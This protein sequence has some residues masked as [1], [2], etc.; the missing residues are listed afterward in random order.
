[1]SGPGSRRCMLSR[2]DLRRVDGGARS[3]AAAAA[4]GSGLG[5]LAPRV[6]V[7]RRRLFR[8]G[9]LCSAPNGVEGV[10]RMRGLEVEGVKKGVVVSSLGV[11]AVP[12]RSECDRTGVLGRDVM[13]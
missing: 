4:S 12:G 11:W 13:V 2:A 10:R 6:V 1:M 9:V 5:G 8:V 3:A 7:E